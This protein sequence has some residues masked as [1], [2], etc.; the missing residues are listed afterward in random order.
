MHYY[1]LVKMLYYNGCPIYVL[2][3]EIQEGNEESNLPDTNILTKPGT[4][5]YSNLSTFTGLFSPQ[6][7]LLI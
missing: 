2:S 1:Y 3:S 4:L 6:Y 5:S 7:H